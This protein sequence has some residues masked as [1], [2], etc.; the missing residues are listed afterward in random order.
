M[1]IKPRFLIVSF[2][3]AGGLYLLGVSAVTLVFGLV[4]AYMA[5]MHLG[6][7][8]GHGGGAG[9]RGRGCGGHAQNKSESDTGQTLARH[10]PPADREDIG[11]R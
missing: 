2:I 10:K 6:H 9:R 11:Q 8:G 7:G 5:S 3:I 4:F 1:S